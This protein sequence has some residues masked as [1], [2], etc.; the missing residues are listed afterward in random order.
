MT[1][2]YESPDL[3]GP[4]HDSSVCCEYGETGDDSRAHLALRC[5]LGGKERLAKFD[6]W[7]SSYDGGGWSNTR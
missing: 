1:R 6:K 2:E 3:G 4:S 5:G 7:P